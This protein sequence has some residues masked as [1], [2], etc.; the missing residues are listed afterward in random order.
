MINK[1]SRLIKRK[2]NK[3]YVH[4]DGDAHIFFIR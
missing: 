3:K 2:T 4:I 1:K